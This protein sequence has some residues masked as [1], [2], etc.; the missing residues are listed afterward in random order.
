MRVRDGERGTYAS[1][2]CHLE[3]QNVC[4]LRQPRYVVGVWRLAD[5][6]VE[7]DRDLRGTTNGC[8][9]GHLGAGLLYILEVLGVER[10]HRR[11]RAG[12]AP[13]PVGIDSNCITRANCITN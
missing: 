12:A 9:F 1:Q 6:F 3:N 4:G 10:R 8:A 2:R 5:G 13:P 11:D 7:W